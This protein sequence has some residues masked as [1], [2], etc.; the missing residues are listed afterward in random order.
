MHELWLIF[1][2]PNGIVVGNLLASAILGV[3]A[4]MHLDKR[5]KKRHERVMRS[6]KGQK[7]ET[8]NGE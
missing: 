1:G 7:A 4:V 6:I 2:W 8:G 5:A 3:P